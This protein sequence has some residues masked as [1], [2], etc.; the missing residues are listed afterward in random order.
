MQDLQIFLGRS[1]RLLRQQP[2][3]GQ[4]EA[5]R[6]EQVVAV[7]IVRERARFTHQP[8]DDVPVVDAM[9]APATQTR[10]AFHLLL[11]VPHLDVVGV[12]AGLDPFANQTAG[13]RVGVAAH[14]DRAAVIHPHRHA[15]AGVQPLRRQRPQQ[16]PIFLKT[17]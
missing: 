13:H 6:R 12:D 9:L 11:G 10:Q 15:L 1:L 5:A 3:I 17:L 8:I 2:V 7:A 16:D 4:P 14:V